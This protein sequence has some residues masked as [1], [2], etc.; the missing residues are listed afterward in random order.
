MYITFNIIS[1]FINIVNISLQIIYILYLK[2][3]F[4]FKTTKCDSDKTIID[5][6]R[7]MGNPMELVLGKKFKLEVWEAIIQKMALNE[8]AHF[9]VH[10]SVCI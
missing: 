7:L 8:V 3:M 6:S 10:K 5:D 1:I 2:V 9:K 4:H